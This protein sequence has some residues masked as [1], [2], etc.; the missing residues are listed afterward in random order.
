MARRNSYRGKYKLTK[1]QFY[2]AYYYAL[3]YDEL[4]KEYT[5]I[6]DT[7]KAITYSDMPKG[8]LNVNSAVEDA[9]IKREILSK[10]IQ[11]IED[12][13]NEAFPEHPEIIL[14]AVTI[15]GMTYAILNK[16]YHLDFGVDKFGDRRRRFYYLLSHKIKYGGYLGK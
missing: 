6:G 15:E 3:S 16:L 11:L 4:V 14:K 5:A 10:Q 2:R 7:A 13:A 12:T 9:A 8:S 1:T